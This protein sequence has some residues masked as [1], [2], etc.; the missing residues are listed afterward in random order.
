MEIP[1]ILDMVA[2]AKKSNEKVKVLQEQ[3]SP[4]LKL[5]LFYAY[6]PFFDYRI[7]DAQF[8]EPMEHTEGFNYCLNYMF[9]TLSDLIDGIYIK[10]ME[11]QLEEIKRASATLNSVQQDIFRKI[12]KKDLG[13]GLTVKI[14]N[15]AFPRITSEVNLQKAKEFNPKHVEYPAL[16]E[17]KCAGHRCIVIAKSENISYVG[18]DN[19]LIRNLHNFDETFRQLAYNERLIFECSVKTVGKFDKRKTYKKMY[20][21]DVFNFGDFINRKCITTLKERKAFLKELYHSAVER[22]SSS[23]IY[24]PNGEIVTAKKQITSY[25]RKQIKKK[26]I[27]GVYVKNLNSFYGYN[28]NEKSY[29]WMVL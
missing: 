18:H 19:V 26:G 6:N 4:N 3:S 28:L 23:M 7:T 14:L 21:Y 16:C 9:T 13:C 11:R 25:Y 17:P 10:N 8:A 27:D 2:K 24:V 12:L 5:I 15:K 29:D 22:L 1:E 20:V